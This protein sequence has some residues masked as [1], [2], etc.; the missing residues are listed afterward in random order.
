MDVLRYAPT[1]DGEPFQAIPGITIMHSLLAL[2]WD[3]NVRMT[4]LCH[5]DM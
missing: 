5:N 1:R 2:S 4:I 3:I